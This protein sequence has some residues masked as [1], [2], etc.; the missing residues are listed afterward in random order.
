MSGNGCV[1]EVSLGNQSIAIDFATQVGGVAVVPNEHASEFGYVRDGN[2]WVY[3][4][5]Q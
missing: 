2:A 1:R 5:K 4:G 3:E